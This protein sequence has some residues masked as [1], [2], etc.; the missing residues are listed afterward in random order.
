[1]SAWSPVAFASVKDIPAGF[2][3][4]KW[5]APAELADRL[6]GSLLIVPAF[7]DQLEGLRDDVG[8]ALP[9]TSAYRSPG[10]DKA[11]GGAGLPSSPHVLGL[12]VD[13]GIS[14]NDPKSY[15]VVKWA[16]FRGFQGVELTTSHIHLDWA[17]SQPNAPRPLLWLA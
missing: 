11:V 12:A 14:A 7:L 4:W 17:P 3:R 13:I 8:F 9:L 10:H 16:L 15:Q 6:D 5:F 1:M 2:W